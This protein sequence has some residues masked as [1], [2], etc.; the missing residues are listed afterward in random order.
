LLTNRAKKAAFDAELDDL[1]ARWREWMVRVEA[2]ICAAAAPVSR[3]AGGP[4]ETPDL[5][6]FEALALA[7]I[8]HFQPVTRAQIGE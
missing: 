4:R 5:S 2:A 8:A 6:K 1:P 7:A 3:A